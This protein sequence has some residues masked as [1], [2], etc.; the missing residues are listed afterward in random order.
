MRSGNLGSDERTLTRSADRWGLWAVALA[1]RATAFLYA[2]TAARAARA[3]ARDATACVPGALQ[4]VRTATRPA[5]LPGLRGTHACVR[6]FSGAVAP[7]KAD[8]PCMQ[9][10]NRSA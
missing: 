3:Q 8:K 4:L 5:R 7:Y 9:G 10:Q 2:L 1:L 6:Q